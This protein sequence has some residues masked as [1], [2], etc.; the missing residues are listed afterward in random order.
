MGVSRSATVVIAYLIATTKMT[1]QE[2]LAAVRAKRAIVRPNR[3]FMSQLQEYYSKHSDS[4]QQPSVAEEQPL[5]KD[6][7][8]EKRRASWRYSLWDPR[9]AARVY[10]HNALATA[11]SLSFPS[12]VLQPHVAALEL[13]KFESHMS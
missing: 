2:A 7:K 12:A 1:P 5:D 4:L 6:G 8:Q 13:W 9:D 3:G 10:M 11:T